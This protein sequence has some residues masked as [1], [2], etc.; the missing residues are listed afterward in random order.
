MTAFKNQ[1]PFK[2]PEGYFEAKEKNLKALAVSTKTSKVIWLKPVLIVLATAACVAL[3][4][5]SIGNNET[6]TQ[7]IAF[8]DISTEALVEYINYNDET[9][10][11]SLMT[12][13][14]AN[15]FTENEIETG[16]NLDL[17]GQKLEEYLLFQQDDLLFD[18]LF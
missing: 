8:A 1:N 16:S 4:F 18:N 2:V 5:I 11:T 10:A 3:F 7:K 14:T 12:E 13:L 6:K 17:D 9:D 15:T